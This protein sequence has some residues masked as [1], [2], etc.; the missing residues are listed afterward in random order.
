MDHSLTRFVLTLSLSTVLPRLTLLLQHVV[1]VE[2]AV[3]SSNDAPTTAVVPQIVVTLAR[4]CNAMA[5]SNAWHVLLSDWIRFSQDLAVVCESGILLPDGHSPDSTLLVDVAVFEETV[6]HVNRAQCHST[7]DGAESLLGEFTI[8]IPNRAALVRLQTVVW[9]VLEKNLTLH[10]QRRSYGASATASSNEEENGEYVAVDLEEL[11]DSFYTATATGDVHV[12]IPMWQQVYTDAGEARIRSLLLGLRQS[13]LSIPDNTE[14]TRVGRLIQLHWERYEAALRVLALL[15]EDWHK[16]GAPSLALLQEAALLV[17]RTSLEFLKQSLAVSSWDTAR[18]TATAKRLATLMSTLVLFPPLVRGSTTRSDVAAV[19]RDSTYAILCETVCYMATLG[20]AE[21]TRLILRTIFAMI[22]AFWREEAATNARGSWSDYSMPLVLSRE[23]IRCLFQ[24]LGSRVESDIVVFILAHL[25]PMQAP[26]ALCFDIHGL[27]EYLID[28]EQCDHTSLVNDRKATSHTV[29]DDSESFPGS[30]RKNLEAPSAVVKRLKVD[31]EKL[32]SAARPAHYFE[33]ELLMFLRA[34]RN[35]VS[36]LSSMMGEEHIL[37]SGTLFQHTLAVSSALRLLLA[38]RLASARLNAEDSF[39]TAVLQ[40]MEEY[41][42]CMTALAN[43]LLAAYAQ[44]TEPPLQCVETVVVCGVFVELSL[45]SFSSNEVFFVKALDCVR[46]TTELGKRMRI[47]PFV[48]DC[49][50]NFDLSHSEAITETLYG[51]SL[52]ETSDLFKPAVLRAMNNSK[53]FMTIDPWK[54][55]CVQLSC[56]SP[57]LEAVGCDIEAQVKRLE[58]IAERLGVQWVIAHTHEEIHRHCMDA[59]H[60]VDSGHSDPIVRLLMWQS[61]AWL[62]AEVDPHFLHQV[63]MTKSAPVAHQEGPRVV[64]F[65]VDLAFGA[66]DCLPREY[67]SR[68]LGKVLSARGW[69][70]LLSLLSTNEEWLEI[71]SVEENS[72]LVV[73]SVPAIEIVGRRL[74]EIIEDSCSVSRTT[75]SSGIQQYFG[76][77]SLSAVCL[78]TKFGRVVAELALNRTIRLWCN[79]DEQASNAKVSTCFF[80]LS[81]L[82][83]CNGFNHGAREPHFSKLLLSLVRE[84]LGPLSRHIEGPSSDLAR[85]TRRQIEARFEALSVAVQ[86]V[87]LDIWAAANASSLLQDHGTE[88]EVYLDCFLP[89]VFAQLVVDRNL[90]AVQLLAGYNHYVLSRMRVDDKHREKARF[91]SCP[92]KLWMGLLHKETSESKQWILQ[93]ENVTQ[94]TCLAPGFVEV[95]LQNVMMTDDGDVLTFFTDKVLQRKLSIKQMVDLKEMILLKNIIVALGVNPAGSESLIRAMKSIALTVDSAHDD[96]MVPETKTTKDAAARSWVSKH[97]MYLLVNVVQVRMSLKTA[98]DRIESL[99][100]LL[101]ALS[102][103]LPTEAPQYFPQI[104]ATIDSALVEESRQALGIKACSLSLLAIEVLATFVRLVAQTQWRVV[105]QNLTSVVVFLAPF[106]LDDDC[107]KENDAS[108]RNSA[109]DLLFW[110]TQGQLGA[111]LAEYFAKIPFLPTTN[112]LNPVRASLKLHGVN[113]DVLRVGINPASP[114]VEV[115]QS[116]CADFGSASGDEHFVAS[117]ADRQSELRRQLETVCPLLDSE[118]TSVRRIVLLHI[119]AVLQANRDLFYMLVDNE[120]SISARRFVTLTYNHSNGK[121][122]TRVCDEGIY[123]HL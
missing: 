97:F 2:V 19:V 122:T 69:R 95:I 11:D 78:Q 53:T 66:P 67:A 45:N 50:L 35:S 116:G 17:A 26:G 111:N 113:F 37:D 106:L 47:V 28:S 62:L 25:F 79:I 105:G 89:F 18:S 123:C 1:A 52:I 68:E 24:F 7:V 80:E 34:A 15:S 86:V 5:D 32:Y 40:L 8:R 102:F 39:S 112:A 6:N 44:S 12:S 74:F 82:A 56:A 104:M 3:V 76:L 88:F 22:R 119:T 94:N 59:L 70:A 96:A 38:A 90:C 99:R 83:E 36:A 33:D 31:E 61:L 103:L 43:A 41:I 81:R 23:C 65:L 54:P 60:L 10:R 58:T 4:F 87:V 48:G 120:G 46:L 108:C 21:K 30:K 71:L 98:D 84:I 72:P 93:L 29:S 91:D 110:L 51:F 85:A 16:V 118:R 55:G 73:D 114:I 92:K 27:R 77:F 13:L 57:H 101:A 117:V 49:L 100:S 115:C 109:V 121:L 75:T 20:D 9:S 42:D 64:P 107:T 14:T 63:S